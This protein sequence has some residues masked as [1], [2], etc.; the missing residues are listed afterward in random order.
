MRSKKILVIAKREYLS[1]IKSRGFW[2]STA[3]LPLFLVAMILVP[4]LVMNKTR[5]NLRI[6]V[7]DQTGEIGPLLIERLNRKKSSGPKAVAYDAQLVKVT[8]DAQA[9][10]SELDREV[11]QE[12][13]D[14]WLWIDGR[15]LSKGQAQYHSQNISNFTT[16]RNLESV[17]SDVVRRARLI[18]AGYDPDQIENL[19]KGVSLN[20]V[21]LTEA[22]SREEKGF[23]GFIFAYLF[24]L[25]L[26]MM[27][28]IYGQQV[29]QGVLEEKSSRVVELVVSS[30][31]PFEFMMG[32]LSGICT[33]GLTQLAIWMVTLGILTA[34]GIVAAIAW[35]PE[36]MVIPALSPLLVVNFFLLFVL[37]FFVFSSIYAAIGASFNSVQE[38]QQ[39]AGVTVVFLVAPI[40]FMM[41]IV[42]D[43]DSTLATILSL[44]PLFTP[45]LMILRIAVKTPPLWQL[46]LA[47]GLTT[48]FMIFMVWVG[49]RIYRVGILMYGKKP[50]LQ[51]IIRWLRYA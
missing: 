17:L 26:Y 22:G 32:K 4:A 23:T 40:M 34:P 47:Y 18:K 24:F 9:K 3:V 42:N 49:S 48:V 15:V 29:M 2:I 37:G 1:R 13:I 43:P 27:L 35:L 36:G 7:V 45:L 14:A 41:P 44:I 46:L 6:A 38:A 19:E 28:V 8:G 20:T 31:T 51:E 30:A 5:T 21:R 16:Q 33:T 39:L 25:L 11:L 10:Q 50:S 12:K